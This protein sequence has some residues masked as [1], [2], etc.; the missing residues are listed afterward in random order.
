MIQLSSKGEINKCL[1]D[2]NNRLQFELSGE[3]RS[4]FV[5]QTAYQGL[6]VPQGSDMGAIDLSCMFGVVKTML[7]V[8][9][10]SANVFRIERVF[11]CKE[12]IEK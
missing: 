12:T 2:K 5:K 3:I 8:V 9:S 1:S 6:A 4:W 10:C 7:C 11:Y